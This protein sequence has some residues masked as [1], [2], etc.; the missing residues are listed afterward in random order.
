MKYIIGATKYAL[1]KCNEKQIPP[2]IIQLSLFGFL[3][4]TLLANTSS[5]RVFLASGGVIMY[6]CMVLIVFSCILMLSCNRHIIKI[7]KSCR[8]RIKA[9]RLHWDIIREKK[10][11]EKIAKKRQKT[12]R[13]KFR[14]H[15]VIKVGFYSDI[16]SLMTTYETVYDNM[17]S[18]DRFKPIYLAYPQVDMNEISNFDILEYFEGKNLQYNKMFDE[19]TKEYVSLESLDLDYIFF[20]RHYIS[21]RP[22]CVK[23]EALKNNSVLCMIPYVASPAGGAT[24]DTVCRFNE[25]LDFDV[26]FVENNEMLNTYIDYRR[27][28]CAENVKLE[29][30]GSPKYD[31]IYYSDYKTEETKYKQV[32][33]YTPR[34]TTSE[35]TCSFFYLKEYFFDMVKKN[36]DIKYIFRPHPLMVV[37]IGK[38]EMGMAKWTEFIKE[39]DQYENA[40]IDLDGDYRSSFKQA[41]VIVTDISSMMIEFLITGKPVIYFEM[42][43]ILSPFN[44]TLS[45]GYYIA[46]SKEDVSVLLE[47]LR[48]GVDPLYEERRRLIK[49]TM[50]LGGVPAAENIKNYV[51]KDFNSYRN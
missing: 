12:L 8:N 2:N 47:Q 28:A 30:V 23:T 29:V 10:E 50:L 1:K 18:D 14:G 51:L 3:A 20:N 35:G 38:K 42:E 49:E 19:N 7:Y 25:M 15:D 26:L 48:G 27:K 33:L 21:R 9:F 40:N 36:Q 34:W 32:I 11:A 43:G 6:L 45:S 13:K 46:S 22:S 4:G 17:C 37:E 44:Q 31:A 5:N 24:L 41:T 16:P 39:F